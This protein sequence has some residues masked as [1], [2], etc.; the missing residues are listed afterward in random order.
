MLAD[1]T[2]VHVWLR[3]DGHARPHGED[4][5]CGCVAHWDDG[6]TGLAFGIPPVTRVLHQVL[7]CFG[8]E[9]FFVCVESALRRGLLTAQDLDWL[10]ENT[11]RDARRALDLVRWDAD[12]GL[13]SLL[14]WRLRRH[15]LRVRT[16]V[17]IPST[18]RVDLLIGDQLIIEADGDGNHDGESHRHRDLVRDANAAMWGYSSLRFDYAMIVHDWDLVERAILATLITLR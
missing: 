12:S 3:G 16:Q 7:L 8:I 13:E 15:G 11:N 5:E 9:E 18:G 10:R 2:A 6:P 4:P 17:S 14:R 1:D